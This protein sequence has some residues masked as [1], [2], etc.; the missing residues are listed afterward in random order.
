LLFGQLAM[1]AEHTSPAVTDLGWIC[2]GAKLKN[3]H[4]KLCI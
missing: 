2:G 3:F 1:E 4:I